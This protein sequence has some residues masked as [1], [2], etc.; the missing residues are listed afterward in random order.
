MVSVL[1]RNQT[2]QSVAFYLVQPAQQQKVSLRAQW[3]RRDDTW[4]ESEVTCSANISSS[5]SSNSSSSSRPDI[6][7][8]A[9]SNSAG[10]RHL[11]AVLLPS[12]ALG[13]QTPATVVYLNPFPI[14]SPQGQLVDVFDFIGWVTGGE[15]LVLTASAVREPVSERSVWAIHTATRETFRI[16][17]PDG[18]YYSAFLPAAPAPPP[19][20]SLLLLTRY[21]PS[22][23]RQ[24]LVVLTP[25]RSSSTPYLSA[26][27][28]PPP[29]PP[30]SCSPPLPPPPLLPDNYALE[31]LLSS[32]GST[33]AASS[34]ASHHRHGKCVT[35]T[36]QCLHQSSPTTQSKVLLSAPCAQTRN[37]Q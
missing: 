30:T 11:A 23:P 10:H 35:F 31:C 16:T 36:T 8:V 37:L 4:I 28:S 13:P 26:I 19:S 18:G 34:A 32:G 12:S 15:W 1:N 25:L 6:I 9:V 33:F 29:P 14:S 17:A 2:L 5:S 7:C 21:G 22:V 20:S 24:S 27:S 3:D